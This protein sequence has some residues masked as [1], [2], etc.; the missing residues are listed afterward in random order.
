MTTQFKGDALW[1]ACPDGGDVDFVDGEPVRSG[2]LQAAVYISLM[3]GNQDDDGSPESKL[4]WWGNSLESDTNRVIRGRTG[5]LIAG[6]PMSSGNLLR[7]EQAAQQDLAWMLSVGAATG[8]AVTAGIEAARRLVLT[9][10][11]EAFDTTN[12]FVFRENWLAG[13]SEPALTC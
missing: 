3:G 4:Q 2:G 8:I 6:I 10:D 1:G 11:V 9:V 12:T 5:T 7:I 13:P